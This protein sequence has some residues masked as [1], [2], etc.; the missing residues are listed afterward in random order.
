MI[1]EVEFFSGPGLRMSGHLYLPEASRNLHAGVVFCHGFGG[2]KEGVPVGLSKLLAAEGYT[3]MAFDYR[4]FGKSE[5]ARSLLNPHEQVE[6]TVHALEYLATC[7]PDVDPERIGLYGTSFGGGVAA[8]AAARSPRPK[9][10]AMSVAVTSGSHWLRNINR[11]SEFEEIKTRSLAALARKVATGEIEIGERFEI[12]VPDATSKLRYTEKVPMA[13]ESAYHVLQHEP[14][15]FADKIS[16][17]VQMFGVADDSLVPYEQTPMF[18]ERVRTEKALKVFERGNHWA[19]YDAAL[20]SVA[21]TTIDW[22]ARHVL[23]QNPERI[24]SRSDASSLPADVR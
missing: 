21:T 12:M 13:I 2:V 1:K 5:G 15:E 6:D 17:P 16:V 24:Y 4:G 3:V 18:Y 19:V 10:L 9:A 23:K 7:V 22:F 11:W 8:I 14:I 20:Q